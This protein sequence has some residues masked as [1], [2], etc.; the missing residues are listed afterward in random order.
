[1]DVWIETA[2]GNLVRASSMVIVVR[3]ENGT[4]NWEVCVS[5][6]APP[7]VFASGLEDE[8]MARRIRNSLAVKVSAAPSKPG[9]PAVRYDATSG[10]VVTIDLEE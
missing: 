1:M 8:A 10:A 5:A 9:T 7:A 2:A 6:S 3:A 4:G